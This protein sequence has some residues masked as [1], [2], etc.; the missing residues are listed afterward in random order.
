MNR[1]SRNAVEIVDAISSRTPVPRSEVIPESPGGAHRGFTQ[2]AASVGEALRRHLD[3][4]CRM[5]T[6]ALLE[7]RYDK[8]RRIGHLEHAAPG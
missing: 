1:A 5:S 3:E 8:F 7:A 4:L 2:T 6:D